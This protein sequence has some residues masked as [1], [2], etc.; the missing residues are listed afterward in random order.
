MNQKATIESGE[1]PLTAHDFLALNLDNPV[2][3]EL[4]PIEIG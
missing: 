1:A 2:Y 4:D 3:R